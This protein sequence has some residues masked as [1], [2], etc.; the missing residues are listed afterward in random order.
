MT[1]EDT[2]RV[3]D[4]KTRASRFARVRDEIR[5]E[6]GQ[7]FGITEFMKPRVEE[8]AG[9]LPAGLGRWLLGSPVSSRL[10]R[11]VDGRQANSHRHAS[12]AFCCFTPWRAASAG[13]VST[14]RFQEENA[15]IVEWLERIEAARRESLLVGGRAGARPKAGQ[16]LWRDS[17]AGMAEFRDAVSAARI[18][19]DTIGWR[20]VAFAP[21]GSGARGRG[22]RRAR[23]GDW[24]DPRRL[25]LGRCSQVGL[26]V[27]DRHAGRRFNGRC[28]R[29][30]CRVALELFDAMAQ[31]PRHRRL[32]S[33][34]RLSWS[35]LA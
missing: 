8:I 34:S 26:I 22:G 4:L 9:T 1:F 11:A 12:A 31:I 16:G 17:R 3:A 20:G 5:A 6:R 14:L 27:A 13:A 19:R 29:E 30:I 33:A 35:S 23:A 7:L 2:I 25:R 15:R 10:A 21:A 18:S 32:E 24:R 28:G